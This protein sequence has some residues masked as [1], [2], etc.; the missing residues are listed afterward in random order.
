MEQDSTFQQHFEIAK[1]MIGEG[2][3]NAFIESYFNQQGLDENIV[4]KIIQQ[5]KRLRN[6][7]LTKQGTLLI[8]L[9]VAILGIGFIS[10]VLIHYNGG[11]IG[12]SLYGLTA[13]G[14]VLL[15]V[16]LAM[17]FH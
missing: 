1:K 4:V 17:I 14:L 7:K 6:A 5:V 9:G 16:G 2:R 11:S 8:L 15:V 13:I 12:F 10:C 3:D